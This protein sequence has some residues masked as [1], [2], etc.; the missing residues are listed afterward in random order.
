M[1]AFSQ[2]NKRIKYVPDLTISSQVRLEDI[3]FQ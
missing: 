1:I 3:Q 2:V